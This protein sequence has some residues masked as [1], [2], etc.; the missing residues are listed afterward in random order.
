MLVSSS[1]WFS[2]EENHAI[3]QVLLEAMMASNR[4]DRDRKVHGPGVGF[5]L[6]RMVRRYEVG[7]IWSLSLGRDGALR[8]PRRVVA[9]QRPLS[10]V[11]H[12]AIRSGPLNAAGVIAAR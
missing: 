9:A 6:K 10:F 5:I 3:K 1:G 2:P 8:R 7:C 11:R 12:P 4:Q